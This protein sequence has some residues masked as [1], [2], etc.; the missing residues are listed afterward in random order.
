M[1]LEELEAAIK[2]EHSRVSQGLLS[3]ARPV[4]RKTKVKISTKT[5]KAKNLEAK[6]GMSLDEM[7]R[8]LELLKKLEMNEKMFPGKENM[9]E[10]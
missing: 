3:G 7:K 4:K 10:V 6:Y 8:K 1:T 5:T 2:R 9:E